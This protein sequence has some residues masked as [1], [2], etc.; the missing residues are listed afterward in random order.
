[1][2]E[3]TV[4]G[5]PSILV[6]G[7]FGSTGHQE[8]NAAFLEEAGAA[9]VLPQDRIEALPGLVE[10]ILSSPERLEAMRTGALA[11]AKPDAAITIADAMLETR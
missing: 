1:V 6:P 7:R 11:I 2:A 8:S 10:E 3:L 9:A 4:T 5:T